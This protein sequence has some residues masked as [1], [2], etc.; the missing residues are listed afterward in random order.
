M[1]VK[2]L[3][4]AAIA[5]AIAAAIRWANRRVSGIY[6]DQERSAYVFASSMINDMAAAPAAQASRDSVSALLGEAASPA[7]PASHAASASIEEIASV[8]SIAP[9]PRSRGLAT[10][11]PFMP[12]APSALDAASAQIAHIASQPG[13]EIEPGDFVSEISAKLN[14][15][16]L[17]EASE[18]PLAC[19]DPEITGVIIRLRGG[20]LI[21]VLDASLPDDSTDAANLLR[22][23]EAVVT[24]GPARSEPLVIRRFGSLIGEMISL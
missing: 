20:Q 14:A 1:F 11:Q 9:G 24:P 17:L 13:A 7:T 5:G 3:I 12:S 16:G 15:G 10:I 22:R 18:G 23:F 2:L 6:E 4:F 19:P 21:A 8:V